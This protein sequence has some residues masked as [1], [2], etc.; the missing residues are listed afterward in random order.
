MKSPNPVLIGYKYINTRKLKQL[1]NVDTETQEPVKRDWSPGC[2]CS[3]CRMSL[4]NDV[5]ECDHRFLIIWARINRTRAVFFRIF[6]SLAGLPMGRHHIYIKSIRNIHLVWDVIGRLYNTANPF[7]SISSLI[8][9]V[10][11]ELSDSGTVG[12]VIEICRRNYTALWNYVWKCDIKIQWNEK[13]S[14]AYG[15]ASLLQIY[16]MWTNW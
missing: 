2:V 13:V 8:Y 12:S 9:S 11:T 10:F 14:K 3:R 5:F 1:T 15:N 7:N 6:V 4:L 16:C